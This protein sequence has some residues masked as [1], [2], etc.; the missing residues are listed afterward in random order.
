MKVLHVADWHLGMPKSPY[1]NGVNLRSQDTL[2]CLEEVLK[3]A[4][5]ERPDY[6]L[7][8]GD[9][10]D[11]AEIRQG[12]SHNEVLQARHAILEL[13]KVSAQVVVMRGTPNHDSAEAFEELKAHY[14]YIPNVHVVTSPQV[15]S[16]KDADIA[17][18]PGFD[19][20]IYR[21][22][23]P[24]LSNEQEN[25]AL[26]QELSNIIL[27]LK[28]QCSPDKK[29]ILMAHYTVPGCN[30]ESSPSMMLTRFEPVI[31][32]EALLAAGYDLVAL[33]HIHRPQKIESVGN[34]FYA[35]AINTIN[36]N[37]ENQERGFW[38]HTNTPSGEWESRFYKTP[39]R[40]MVT[41]H[42]SDADITTI[43]AGNIDE[44][45]CNYWRYNGAVRDKIV[46]IHYSCASDNDKAYKMKSALVEKALLEDNAFMLWENI[47]EKVEQYT[48][49]TILDNTTD[50]EVNLM[51][52]LEEKQIP[53]DKVQGLVQKARPIIA[54]AEAAMPAAV[55]TGTFEPIEISVRNYRNYEEETFRFED[56]SFCTINGQNGA[57]KSSLF[58]DAI[59]DCLYEQPR[60][61]MIKDDNK[62]SPWIRNDETVRS[63]SI[64]FTFRIGEKMYRVTR[65]RERS[66]GGKLNIAC[67]MDGRWENCSKERMNDTQQEVLNIIGMDSF[68]FKSCALIMQ[69]QY[70]LFLQAKPEERGEALGTLLGLGIYQIMEKISQ[71]KA[72]VYGAKN[73]E[74][75][76]EAEIHRSTIAGFGNPD[77]ELDRCRAELAGYESSLQIKIAERDKNK[78]LLTNQQEAAERRTKLLAS[79]YYSAKQKGRYRPE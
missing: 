77:E 79:Y 58:M 16:F 19:K 55:H 70:G 35:G 27:G 53:P 14:E 23:C 42:F 78:L 44:V 54:E 31:P 48:N 50:P 65:T 61:G 33:G 12:R 28:A 15:L 18:L 6:T 62:K 56:I 73:R 25:E 60:E 8:C 7:V 11:K 10:F 38:I 51:K 26:T 22:V 32:Q 69:D 75:K 4:R 34:C 43:N 17:V 5:E 36:F 24:E 20:G 2:R 47:P 68:V 30:M 63:G 40:K 64:M 39:Y 13:A 21:A 72:K 3:V 41:L 66:G 67:F 57:G 45:A 29:S 9:I 71:D 59:V 52:Y 74:L 46:R 1:E 49:R 37:D 76:Q